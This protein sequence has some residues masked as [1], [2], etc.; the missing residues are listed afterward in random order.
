MR[1][2]AVHEVNLAQVEDDRPAV[3]VGLAQGTLELWDCGEV[4]LAGGRHDRDR[5]GASLIVMGQA[6]HAAPVGPGCGGLGHGA[7]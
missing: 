4:E 6:E 7:S 2:G 3:G 1:A 5:S